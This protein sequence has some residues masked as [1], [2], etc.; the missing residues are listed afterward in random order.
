VGGDLGGAFRN[1]STSTA[2]IRLG[3]GS[4]SITSVTLLNMSWT[5][6]SDSK[7]WTLGSHID[8]MDLLGWGAGVS[9]GHREGM[10][11]GGIHV[12]MH[13]FLSAG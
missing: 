4:R 3:V 7:F 5:L 8:S 10:L 11:L 2:I 12:L 9:G 6:G 1:L 13:S